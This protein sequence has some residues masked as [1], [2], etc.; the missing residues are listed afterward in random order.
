[1]HMVR[2]A[3]SWWR[4]IDPHDPQTI[5]RAERL[6]SAVA[7]ALHR[8]DREPDPDAT[9]E[10][11]VSEPWGFAIS[12]EHASAWLHVRLPR[13]VENKSESGRWPESIREVQVA[14]EDGLIR[15]GARL[16]DDGE[17]RLLSATIRP[18]LR[19]D[20]SLWLKVEQARLGRLPLPSEWILSGALDQMR[21]AA[22]DTG[23]DELLPAL[24]EVLASIRPLSEDAIIS[25][26]DGRRVRLLGLQA[27]PGRIE[28]I[29]QTEIPRRFA[30]RE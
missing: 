30:D 12:Q 24:I 10:L 20:G 17:Q 5:A 13:W 21:A 25:L 28:V 7:G 29:C 8:T 15:V 11:W 22:T 19:E 18:S 14:F 1:M 9:P 26:G 27:K 3:P 4:P 6:E 23:E 16:M 2:V